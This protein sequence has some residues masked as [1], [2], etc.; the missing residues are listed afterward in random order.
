M[1]TTRSW[2]SWP[3]RGRRSKIRKTRALP[4]SSQAALTHQTIFAVAMKMRSY[5]GV[6][7]G[8]TS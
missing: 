5:T 6:P 1:P 4:V 3:S 7:S 8:A 2:I